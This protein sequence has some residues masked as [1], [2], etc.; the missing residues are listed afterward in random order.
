[1]YLLNS[2]GFTSVSNPSDNASYAY[3]AMQIREENYGGSG[4]DS[5]GRAPRLAW[6]WS[7]RVAAQIGLASNGYLYEAPTTGTTFYK[8]TYDTGSSR[9]IKHNIIPLPD[10][11]DKID[12]LQPVSFIYN[13]LSKDGI[14]YG[15]IHEDTINILPDICKF[16]KNQNGGCIINYIDLIPFLIKEIQSLRRRVKLLENN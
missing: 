14:R 8:I 10:M 16:D 2:S 11:G 13:D 12:L 15:L 3:A 6:H 1:M 9:T 7:G 4:T 5:W